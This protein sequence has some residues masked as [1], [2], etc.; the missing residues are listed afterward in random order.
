MDVKI[1]Q[2]NKTFFSHQ[3]PIDRIWCGALYLQAQKKLSCM[4]QLI[5]LIVFIF[6]WMGCSSSANDTPSVSSNDNSTNN[7]LNDVPA[8]AIRE[9]FPDQPE[10]EK[11]ILKD[12]S[13]S[14]ILS[15]TLL[16]GKKNGVWTEF[17]NNGAIKTMT[18]YVNG[19]KEGMFIE[20]NNNGQVVKKC[21]YHNNLRHGQYMEFEYM[22]TKEERFYQNDK[23]EGTVKIYYSGGKIMEE[24]SYKNGTRHGISKWY[25]QEGNVTIEYEY[26]EGQ[27]VKK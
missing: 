17:Q 24:G 6:G 8:G 22:S 9:V 25:D 26:Q 23:L 2:Q 5:I 3:L 7:E 20:V 13:G 14:T 15:G 18:G 27:L 1:D 11:V 21:E 16:N 10:M 12:A 4:R 19:L